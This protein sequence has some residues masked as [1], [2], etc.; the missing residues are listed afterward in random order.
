[1]YLGSYI[2]SII[3][4][5]LIRERLPLSFILPFTVLAAMV[6]ST[7]EPLTFCTAMFAWII[8]ISSI[9]FG[10]IGVN[11]AHHHPDIFHDGDTPR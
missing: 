10:I 1:M 7:S 6:V 5:L 8:T 2:K 3:Q 11:A 9:C 4:I